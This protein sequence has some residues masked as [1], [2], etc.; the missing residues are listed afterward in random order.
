MLQR[1]R[2]ALRCAFALEVHR[3]TGR[4][5]FTDVRTFL[6]FLRHPLLPESKQLLPKT[7]RRAIWQRIETSLGLIALM[8][9][10]LHQMQGTLQ[11]ETANFILKEKGVF[12]GRIVGAESGVTGNMDFLPS[13]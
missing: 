4:C 9:S 8:R 10:T 6:I 2:S 5:R 7:Q 11:Q 13:I 12:Q 1:G 3:N